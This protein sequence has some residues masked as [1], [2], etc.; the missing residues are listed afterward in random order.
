MSERVYT[1]NLSAVKGVARIDRAKKA[2]VLIRRFLERHMKG[3]VMISPA[4][5]EYVWSRGIKKPPVRVKVKATKDGEIVK[6]ELVETEQRVRATK[7]TKKGKIGSKKETAKTE[8][9]AETKAG[10]KIEK[11]SD[12]KPKDAKPETE[13]KE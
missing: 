10:K 6:A 12:E 4:L 13:K 7:K 3:T 11:A 8:A 1:I 9:P 5:N 2:V